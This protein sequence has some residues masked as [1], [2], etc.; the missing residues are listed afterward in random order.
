VTVAAW[1]DLADDLYFLVYDGV[2]GNP[3]LHQRA[4]NFGLASALIAELLLSGWATM[5]GGCLT[6]L[7]ARSRAPDDFRTAQPPSLHPLWRSL[8]GEPWRLPVRTWLDAYGAQAHTVVTERLV[9]G[10]HLRGRRPVA[11]NM[12]TAGWPVA[13]VR[14]A[15]GRCCL[16]RWHDVVLLALAEAVGVGA[17]LLDDLE[18]AA[19]AYR[20]LV[21]HELV[22]YPH[23]SELISQTAAAVGGAVLTG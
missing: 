15:L 11:V 12:N 3:R 1:L 13:R 18:P 23:F 2:R 7:D 10:G 22:R 20:E 19:L 8:V 14:G 9:A 21:L 16:E 4:V 17:L 5:D 6:A